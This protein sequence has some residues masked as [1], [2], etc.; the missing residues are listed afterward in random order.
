MWIL[1]LGDDSVDIGYIANSKDIQNIS[2][3]TNICQKEDPY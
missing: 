2:S 3:T 1:P